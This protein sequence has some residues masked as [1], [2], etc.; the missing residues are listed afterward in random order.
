M[1]VGIEP[2]PGTNGAVD[3]VAE[4]V[5]YSNTDYQIIVTTVGLTKVLGVFASEV[6][7]LSVGVESCPGTDG[8]V[9]CVAEGVGNVEVDVKSV[10]ATTYAV[11]QQ[12][13]VKTCQCVT[14]AVGIEPCTSTDGAVDSVTKGVRKGEVDVKSVVAATYA[15]PQQLTVKTCPCVTLTVGVESCPGTDGA[16]DGV[17]E[18]VVNS[19]TDY[20][21]VVTAV[22]LT[23]V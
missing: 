18:G 2:G 1:A 9:D 21:I 22:G 6:V 4:G 19:E 13:T 15:V 8:A 17:A 3:G 11:P 14:L 16:V 5:V 12:L 23:K 20:Q 10:V 7:T